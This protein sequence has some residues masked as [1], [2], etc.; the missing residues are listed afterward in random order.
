MNLKLNDSLFF[1]LFLIIFSYL[2]YSRSPCLFTSGRYYIAEFYF[3]YEYSN[4]N[5]LFDSLKY[6]YS[7][8]KY[9]E[10]WTNLSAI[11][12]TRFGYS[13]N[14]IT[15]YF[16]FLIKFLIIIYILLSK[17]ILL[18]DKRYKLIFLSFVI[19]STSI[20]PEVWLTTL[21]TKSFFGLLTYIMVFQ[22]FSKFNKKKIFFFRAAIVFNGLSSIYSS[23][24]AISFFFRF[25]FEKN[26]NNFINFI[27][28]LLPLIINL[29]IFTYYSIIDFGINSRFIYDS[30]KILNL[31]YNTLIRPIFGGNISKYIFYEYLFE[32]KYLLGLFIFIIFSFFCIYIYKKKDLILN[33]IITS[34]L[35]NIAFIF[36][37]SLYS[38]FVGGRYA[39]VSSV[40]FLSLFIRLCIFEKNFFLQK[41]YW[42]IIIFSI[43]IGFYEFKYFNSWIYLLKCN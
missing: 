13:P 4:T 12:G 9:F 11:F 35:T 25:F 34:F 10:L 39:V 8:A 31:I 33:I 7:E 30:D 15:V 23:I 24:A 37:G 29:L 36:F 2:I 14:L 22:D 17:S 20:T 28:S 41:I 40:V 3:F 38:D 27:Y 21:H 42:I 19:I 26:K 16:A 18:I 6:V 32:F 5:N 43:F 1:Y